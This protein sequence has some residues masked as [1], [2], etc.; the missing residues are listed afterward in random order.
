MSFSSGDS[1]YLESE[2][3]WKI[4]HQLDI[5]LEMVGFEV[6]IEEGLR[7]ISEDDF[8]EVFVGDQNMENGQGVGSSLRPVVRGDQSSEV[9]S[10]FGE[11]LNYDD[12][13]FAVAEEDCE[14]IVSMP[15]F[16]SIIAE[17]LELEKF[18]P[19]CLK[20]SMDVSVGI[21]LSVLVRL[22]MASYYRA[23]WLSCV[24]MFLWA[25]CD[26]QLARHYVEPTS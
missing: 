4:S 9:Q 13:V 5:L 3:L 19:Y 8:E 10:L 1:N 11:T 23:Q 12:L 25:K 26:I 22:F 7:S 15:V 6:P 2:L 17:E 20:H 21:L 18:I 16:S 24:T 14:E